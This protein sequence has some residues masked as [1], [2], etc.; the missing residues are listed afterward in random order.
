[1]SEADLSIA[2]VQE[3]ENASTVM[4][5]GAPHRLPRPGQENVHINALYN[6]H[7]SKPL[8]VDINGPGPQASVIR[9]F[10]EQADREGLNPDD[11][12]VQEIQQEWQGRDLESLARL[13][14]LL[15]RGLVDY[16]YDIRYGRIR[17]NE[18]DSI[19][20]TEVR[21]EHFDSVEVISEVLALPDLAAYI[22]S[23]PPVHRY[24]QGLKEMLARYRQLEDEGGWG[25]IMDG[26]MIRPG[27]QDDRIPA[28]RARL[29]ATGDL[30]PKAFSGNMYEN[31]LELAVRR[32]QKRHGLA[33][34]GVIGPQTRWAMNIPIREVIRRISLNMARW[35]WREHDLGGRYVLVNIA[36]YHL[37]AVDGEEVELDMAVIVGQEQYQT[38]V[39]SD[40]IKYLEFNPYWNIPTSIARDEYLPQLQQDPWDLIH[41]NIRL[42]SDWGEEALELD[43][44]E[45]D[46]QRITPEEME[47]FKLRQDPGAWNVLGQVKFIFP[48]HYA[49]YLHDTVSP[50]LFDRAERDLSHGCVRVSNPLDLADFV[51]DG[52]RTGWDRDWVHEQLAGGDNVIVVIQEPLPVHITYQTAWVDKE[53]AFRLNKDIYGRDQRLIEALFS[54]DEL[55]ENVM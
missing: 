11:Y 53:G 10:L 3:L 9:M 12:G 54:V 19:N 31:K 16:I 18:S 41:N 42:F 33:S 6:Q 32:F 25:K 55:S 34:D 47:R 2:L 13:D 44:T 4:D 51:L 8:W 5:R 27:D 22:A 7:F 35:R 43:S 38:P 28:V 15:T 1:M 21:N 14:I 52:M 50:Q 29:L 39:F 20:V 49:V 17:L 23:L 45:I 37:L 26:P 30:A 24:Y 46:W 40:M 36:N 48:N